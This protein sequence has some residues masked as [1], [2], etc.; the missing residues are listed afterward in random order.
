MKITITK[1]MTALMASTAM[2]FALWMGVGSVAVAA[3]DPAPQDS[4]QAFWV[5]EIASGLNAPWGM[6]WLPDGTLLIT[7][8]FGG[9]RVFRHGQLES[10]PL[11]G[12][13][14]SV[15]QAAQS[16]LLDIVLDPDFATNQR[17]FIAYTEGTAGA[18]RGAIYRARYTPQGLVEGET[19]FR[20]SPDS[21]IFPF[22]LAGRIQFLPDR[23]FLFTSSDDHARRHLAQ[24]LDNH[25]AKILRLDRDGK[26]PADNPFIGTPGALPEIY[27]YGT[28][29]P[30]G[31]TR[32]PRNGAIWA[33]ENGPQG[34]DEL[35]LI[36]A[37]A[38][39]GWPI[40]TYGLEYTGEVI[41]ELQQA[42]GIES[43]VTYWFPAIA[44][45]SIALYL[46]DKL[47]RWYGNLF[48]GTLRG[49]HLLR[50]SVEN[51]VVVE[52]E[53]LLLD[54]NERIRDV[55]EGPDGLLY[56]LTDSTD[57][58]LL[59][60]NPG[61]PAGDQVARQAQAPAVPQGL[62][63]GGFPGPR[64]PAD[65]AR[66]Q[67]IF[68]QRCMSCHTLEDTSGSGIG[69]SLA[70][71]FG[72]QPGAASGFAFSAAMQNLDIIW[73]EKTIEYYLASPQN[74]VP[75][76]VMVAPPMTDAIERH[77]LIGYLK[78]ATAHEGEGK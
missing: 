61:A 13:P 69:P 72:R 71:V 24:R 31:I 25:L 67:Q 37:G 39:Y 76:S 47:P 62:P 21:S 66:G 64:P 41:S 12:G 49:Q 74:Y 17:V 44:P 34:G 29:A 7:E 2:G 77:D 5:E 51:G 27:A 57:G 9:V 50:L 28:R 16:G 63:L 6:A 23:T 38:N 48:V 70:G 1:Q 20:I 75:G 60:L 33:V 30:L 26:A 68:E 40:T 36:K 8:K 53:K 3:A 15:Y 56:V 43:P 42:P 52:Q 55:R 73:S 22:P 45:S 4:G 32:D 65:V 10:E 46:G 19:I 59:R 14:Q 58:R 11:P 78:M 18:N 54:L 35:N